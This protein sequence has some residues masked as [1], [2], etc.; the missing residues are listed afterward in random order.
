M[1]P[2]EVCFSKYPSVVTCG[3]SCKPNKS[4]MVTKRVPVTCMSMLDPRVFEIFQKVMAGQTVPE[5]AEELTRYTN[6]IRMPATCV[7]AL[8]SP[9]PIRA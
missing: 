7:H 9:M 8:V 3:P 1:G 6:I 5:L 2:E 4:E